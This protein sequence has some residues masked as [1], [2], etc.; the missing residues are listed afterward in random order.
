MYDPEQRSIK[1]IA[2]KLSSSC[3]ATM[4]IITLFMDLWRNGRNIQNWKFPLGGYFKNL[5][6]FTQTQLIFLN[7]IKSE[8]LE[9]SLSG[10]GTICIF[11]GVL[12][13]FLQRSLNHTIYTDYSCKVLRFVVWNGVRSFLK[14]HSLFPSYDFFWWAILLLFL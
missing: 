1:L 2:S 8:R 6:N 3:H 5:C 7:F 10:N 14:V 9:S 4:N 13:P 12:H 11:Y